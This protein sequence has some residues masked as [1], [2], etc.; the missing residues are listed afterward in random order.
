MSGSSNPDLFASLPDVAGM[1]LYKD[2]TYNS[3][4]YTGE[5][6]TQGATETAE[7]FVTRV[8]SATLPVSSN[9][10]VDVCINSSYLAEAHVIGGTGRVRYLVKET[11]SALTGACAVHLRA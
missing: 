8:M 3:S 6:I 10:G 2:H 7:D 11:N 9:M 1:T 5:V 4:Q